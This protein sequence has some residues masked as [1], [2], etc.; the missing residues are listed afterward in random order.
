MPVRL[1]ILLQEIDT[2]LRETGNVDAS[3][4]AIVNPLGRQRQR[5]QYLHVPDLDALLARLLL[6]AGDPEEH[7]KGDARK[8]LDRIVFGD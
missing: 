6:Q 7:R 4:F 1:S 3:T 2:V 5:L 8:H